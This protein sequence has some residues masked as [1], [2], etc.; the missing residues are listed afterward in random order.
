MQDGLQ[1]HPHPP[2]TADA[3]GGVLVQHA[4]HQVGQGIGHVR[5]ST[6]KVGNR[7]GEDGGE[8]G[9]KGLAGERRLSGQHL[10][11]HGPKGPDVGPRVLRF[12]LARLR[13]EVENGADDG[14]R[15]RE[16][17][18][19]RQVRDAE[20]GQAGR[21][22]CGQEHVRGLEVAVDDPQAVGA[23]QGIGHVEGDLDRTCDRQ[24]PLSLQQVQQRP[25]WNELYHQVVPALLL[26]SIYH[27][28]DV[29]MVQLPQRFPL[30]DEAGNGVGCAGHDLRPEG[31]DGD[32][33]PGGD[34]PR[35]AHVAHPA[36]TQ[37]VALPVSD[38]ESSSDDLVSAHQGLSLSSRC[39]KGMRS[40]LL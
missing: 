10:V 20:I 31:L 5:S 36:P 21:P 16:P 18:A 25:A 14:S 17:R 35:P 27:L 29:G 30:A 3:L 32:Q 33:F 40:V 23:G 34:V 39:P 13:A 24:R 1:F 8:H 15:T 28:D 11:E 22:V 6:G 4:V 26:H 37:Q 19:G 38:L 12:T 7:L 2:H 9:G